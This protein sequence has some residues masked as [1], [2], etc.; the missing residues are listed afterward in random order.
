MVD[1]RCGGRERMVGLEG[2]RD[3]YLKIVFGQFEVGSR[4]L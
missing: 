1:G 4:F 3:R 2:R